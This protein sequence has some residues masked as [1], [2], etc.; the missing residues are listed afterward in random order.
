MIELKDRANTQ[1][2][3]QQFAKSQIEVLVAGTEYAV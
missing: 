2:P 1:N 3:T